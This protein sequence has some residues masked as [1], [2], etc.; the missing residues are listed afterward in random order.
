MFQF[1]A[2]ADNYESRRVGREDIDDNTFIST[3][4]VNDGSKPYETAVEHPE[5][6]DGKM[7][8][9]ESYDTRAEAEEGH[10][11]WVAA[12]KAEQL[13]EELIDCCNAE[14]AEFVDA[15]SVTADELDWKRHK[16]TPSK[17]A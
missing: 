4:E 3:A 12:M 1:L 9:V 16:R 17:A 2:M 15:L 13:P 7:V 8:I 14:I 10:A 11:K 6:N 5:Y